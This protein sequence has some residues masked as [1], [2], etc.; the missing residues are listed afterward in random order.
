MDKIGEA[1]VALIPFFAGGT[2][3]AKVFNT[4]ISAQVLRSAFKDFMK[5]VLTDISHCV[6]LA[7]KGLHAVKVAGCEGLE[8]CSKPVQEHFIWIVSDAVIDEGWYFIRTVLDRIIGREQ[9]LDFFRTGFDCDLE[10]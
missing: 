10:W 1:F 7:L 4:N 3:N 5:W 2:D 8:E 6:I 9:L